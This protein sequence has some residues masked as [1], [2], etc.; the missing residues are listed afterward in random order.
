MGTCYSFCSRQDMGKVRSHHCRVQNAAARL[1][2]ELRPKEHVTPSLLQLFLHCHKLVNLIFDGGSSLSYA[3]SCTRSSVAT[4]R[5]TWRIPFVLSV[6]A[7]PVP[8]SGRH[9][10][11]TT[12]CLAYGPSSA[13]VLYYTLVPQLGTHCLRTFVRHQ[14]LLFLEDSS[15]LIILA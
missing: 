3:V 5:S 11:P 13:S 7:D 1:V 8:V 9:L 6:P 4:R 14:T 2:F 15:Q 12:H 10:P